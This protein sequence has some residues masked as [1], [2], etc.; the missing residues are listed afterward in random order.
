MCR[1]R[2]TLQEGFKHPAKFGFGVVFNFSQN[3]IP[4]SDEGGGKTVG[5]DGR[6]DNTSFNY[7][8]VSLTLASSLVRGSYALIKI[9][10]KSQEPDKPEFVGIL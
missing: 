9:E 8:S 7:T 1:K 6:R 5:F 3:P 10:S 2:H 4:P